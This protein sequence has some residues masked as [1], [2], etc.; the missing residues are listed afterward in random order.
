MCEGNFKKNNPFWI[1]ASDDAKDFIT[2]LLC[3]E[4]DKRMTAK[5]VSLMNE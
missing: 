5:E 4:P 2:R 1:Q 3:A